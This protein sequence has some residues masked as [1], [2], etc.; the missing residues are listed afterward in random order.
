MGSSVWDNST[1]DIVVRSSSQVIAHTETYYHVSNSGTKIGFI[2]DTDTERAGLL[3]NSGGFNLVIV[4]VTETGIWHVEFHAPDNALP[5]P[6]PVLS[7]D[8]F[9]INSLQGL[10]AAA[11]NITVKSGSESKKGRVFSNIVIAFG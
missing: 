8:Q 3:A 6:T 1:V 2:Y 4:P 10:G 7:N 5:S 11:W 9:P